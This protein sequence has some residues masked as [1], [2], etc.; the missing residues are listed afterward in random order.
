M[1][2]QCRRR[3]CVYGA[4]SI[5]V[6][7]VEQPRDDLPPQGPLSKQGPQNHMR[8][9]VLY[10]DQSRCCRAPRRRLCERQG[11]ADEL[12]GQVTGTVNSFHSE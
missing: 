7:F 3:T 11:L 9:K 12:H 4:V 6:E 8:P 2:P 5:G 1:L 10:T